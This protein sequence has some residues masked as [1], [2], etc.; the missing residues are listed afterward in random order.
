MATLK[1]LADET[2]N[3]KN[4][5]IEC[6]NTLKQIL[7]DKKIEGLENEHKLPI[8]IDK[9]KDLPELPS[10]VYLY[11]SG[12]ENVSVTGGW[13]FDTISYTSGFGKAREL[14]TKGTD[15]FYA[16]LPSSNSIYYRGTTNKIDL[17][18]YSKLKCLLNFTSATHA[19]VN[20]YV[21]KDDASFTKNPPVATNHIESSATNAILTVDISNINDSYNI[22]ISL[23]C[24]NASGGTGAKLEVLQVWLER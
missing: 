10:T 22:F 23:Y 20:L 4:E 12:D 7:I 11:K 1:S 6:R 15:K 24:G 16:T 3:I 21:S 13:D 17:T 2:T 9:V 8:L 18:K 14:M 19:G 5:I